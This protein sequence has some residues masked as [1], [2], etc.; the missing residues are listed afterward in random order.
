MKKLIT[1][2]FICVTGIIACT[3]KAVPSTGATT[4][5]KSETAKSEVAKMEAGK[6]ETTEPT[7]TDI[8]KAE[9]TAKKTGS[10]KPSDE[11][12]GKSVYATKCSSCHAAK[13]V[14]S[15]TFNQ[16]EAILKRMVPNAKLS[17]D[18]ESQVVAY[19]KT[20]SK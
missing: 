18:E 16:W 2:S 13:N 4:P 6:T 12:T 1:L 20:N 3:K 5:A 14:S 9:A 10:E 11:E 19:I 8:A 15:Y 17:A 7:K